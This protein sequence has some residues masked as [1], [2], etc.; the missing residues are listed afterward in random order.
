MY[1]IGVQDGERIIPVVVLEDVSAAAPLAEALL[2]GGLRTV[3][4]TFRTAA[5]ADAIRA[6]AAYPELTVGAGTALTADQVDAAVDAGARFVVTPGFGPAVVARCQALDVPVHPGIAT[7]TEI[8]MALDAGLDTVKFFPAEQL[9]GPAMIKALAA[10]FRSVKFIPTGG[11]NAGNLRSYLDLPAVVAVGGS[12]MVAPDLLAAGDWA[13][14]TRRTAA[15]VAAAG[16]ASAAERGT[17]PATTG[18][19]SAAGETTA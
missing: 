7:A 5:A 18:P 16:A 19:G 8:Q 11:V 9:G 4:V 17:G 14:V 12:W 10:P 2:A 6:M 15:A 3:E 1:V 13:T